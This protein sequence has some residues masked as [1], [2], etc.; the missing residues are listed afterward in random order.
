MTRTIHPAAVHLLA[1]VF[2]ILGTGR[3]TAHGATRYRLGSMRAHIDADGIV[4]W[5]AGGP[6]ILATLEPSHPPRPVTAPLPNHGRQPARAWSPAGQRV[7]RPRPT[8]SLQ[9]VG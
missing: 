6:A 5:R 1:A 9:T 2:A 8:F 3:T 4:L 7:H